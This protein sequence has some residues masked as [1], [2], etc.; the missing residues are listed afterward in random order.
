MRET[1][2]ALSPRGRVT[3]PPE[4]VWYAAY[5]SNMSL[6]RLGYYLSGGR[7][8]GAVRTYP[9][10]RD[11]RPPR[12]TRPLRL[13][14]QTYFALESPVWGGGTAFLDPYTDGHSVLA[15]HLLT[16]E[17]FHDIAAQEMLR[18]P[19][20]DL[21]PTTALTT[22]RDTVGPGRYET[23]VC[24]GWL[25]GAPVLTFTSPWRQDEVDTTAPAPA[26]L[27]QLLVGL[28]ESQGWTPDRA[29]HHLAT[30]PGAAGHWT[31]PRIRELL[32]VEPVEGG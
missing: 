12:V 21:D 25:E 27:R 31:A 32:E 24:P 3:T 28:V 23:L 14:G 13:P 20:T 30:R 26:Y 16:L 2:T 8:P 29:A 22:G 9:G 1:A 17:Q 15:A 10:C 5:G 11:P 18:E 6:S 4:R 7:P 19:G